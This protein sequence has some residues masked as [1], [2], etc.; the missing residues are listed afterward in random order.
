M[1]LP[2]K[3][4][5]FDDKVKLQSEYVIADKVPPIGVLRA[6]AVSNRKL[7]N[8]N[9]RFRRPVLLH[10]PRGTVSCVDGFV[11]LV[12]APTAVPPVLKV[13]IAM[14]STVEELVKITFHVPTNGSWLCAKVAI[15]ESSTR[16]SVAKKQA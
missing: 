16:A 3:A 1:Q 7:A 5:V 9:V 12:A 6:F 10:L 2:L 8:L 15:G 11:P 13:K 14:E 4:L